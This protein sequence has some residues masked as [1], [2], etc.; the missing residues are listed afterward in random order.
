METGNCTPGANRYFGKVEEV[1]LWNDECITGMVREFP[2]RSNQFHEQWSLQK[3]LGIDALQ[4]LVRDARAKS[5]NQK[6][7]ALEERGVNEDSLSSRAG[8]H[9][10]G[11]H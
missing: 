7:K 6:A 3:S 2:F 9:G 10:K 11:C 1:L 8:G 5:E 4:D